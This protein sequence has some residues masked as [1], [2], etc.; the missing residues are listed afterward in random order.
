MKKISIQLHKKTKALGIEH[1]R[2]RLVM[3]LFLTAT[4]I[5]LCAYLYFV[6]A[7]VLNVMARREALQN[8]KMLQASIG[9]LQQRYF[10]LSEGITT[11]MAA[12]LGLAP[13]VSTAYVHRPGAVGIVENARNAI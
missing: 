7:S 11:E 6:C 8:S 13:I 1:P 12:S 9:V 2:E 4:I 5:L 3:Q 10:T